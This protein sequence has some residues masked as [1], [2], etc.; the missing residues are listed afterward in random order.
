VLLLYHAQG[1]ADQLTIDTTMKIAINDSPVNTRKVTQVI[2]NERDNQDRQLIW[3]K[4]DDGS[5]DSREVSWHYSAF[6]TCTMTWREFH[7]AGSEMAQMIQS[8]K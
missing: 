5:A 8:L 6:Q 4:Y 2:R 3:T 7:P 1:S